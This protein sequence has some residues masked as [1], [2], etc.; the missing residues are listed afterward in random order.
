MNILGYDI[1]GFN[2]ILTLN[3]ILLVIYASMV[4]N[5][6][7]PGPGV[8]L[9]DEQRKLYGYTNGV[10]AT[11]G[12]VLTVIDVLYLTPSFPTDQ[13]GL[14]HNEEVLLESAK[15]A[16]IIILLYLVWE[17]SPN[18]TDS[19]SKFKLSITPLVPFLCGMAGSA[20]ITLIKNLDLIQSVNKGILGK[21]GL[22][23]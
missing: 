18:S 22:N 6:T 3:I 13:S 10:G 9:T 19:Y 5:T 8:N 17:Y 23:E 12:V 15:L 4:S 1:T 21:L 2:V 11:F 14:L 16:G 20:G 7:Y